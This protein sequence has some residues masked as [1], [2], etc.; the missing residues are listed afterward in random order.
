MTN[1]YDNAFR[2]PLDAPEIR[3]DDLLGPDVLVVDSDAQFASTAEWMLGPQSRCVV[4]VRTAAQALAEMRPGRFDVALIELRTGDPGG[5]DLVSSLLDVDAALDVVAVGTDPTG[6]EVVDALAHG[7]RRWILKPFD[8][9]DLRSCVDETWRDRCRR[10]H[11]RRH[12]RRLEVQGRLYEALASALKPEDVGRAGIDAIRELAGDWP[13][14]VLGLGDAEGGGAAETGGLRPL[15]WT[16]LEAEDAAAL[17]G[18]APVRDHLSG[19][20]AGAPSAVELRLRDR[21]ARTF[22]LYRVRGRNADSGLLAVAQGGEASAER[23]DLLHAVVLWLGVAMERA[24]LYRRL[25]TAFSEVKNAQRRMV[26]AEK[27]SAVGRLAAGLA[28]E[29]GTPLNIISGRAEYLL[30]D[31]VSDPRTESGLRIIVSQIERI[32]RLIAQVLEFSREYSPARARIDLDSVLADVVPLLDR[33]LNKAKT[34]LSLFLPRGLPKVVANFNHMQQV[35]INLFMNAIDAIAADPAH[36]EPKGR[37]RIVVTAEHQP[38]QRKVSVRVEDNGH[39]IRE[40]H[41]DQVF[42]PFFSTKPVGTGTGLGL[43]VVYGIVTE[44]GGTIEVDSRM[45]EGATFTFTLPTGEDE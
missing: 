25:E 32:S 2:G 37:G 13:A 19:R 45:G 4:A 35:F 10:A 34:D 22:T 18:L 5:P 44:H 7:V 40:E 39:G 16:G 21:T 20:A 29:V 12:V 1:S 26:Q 11:E 14:V 17:A 43:A 41:L 24:F 15:A 42:D 6:R 31:G 3:R 38:R 28:H 36:P 9:A 30:Q 8:A 23:A 33:P 27:L